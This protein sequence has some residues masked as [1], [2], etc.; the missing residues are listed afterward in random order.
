[1]SGVPGIG[2]VKAAVKAVLLSSAFLVEL[3]AIAEACADD[4]PLGLPAADAV[5]T[6]ERAH[7]AS[8]PACEI[9]GDSSEP[10]D[11]NQEAEEYAHRL[12]LVWTA[13]DDDEERVTAQIERFVLASRRVFKNAV[14]AEVPGIAPVQVGREDFSPLGRREAAGPFLKS[15]V[16]ELTV[17]TIE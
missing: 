9:V 1:M 17:P 16:L 13:I 12:A 8:Y 3:N 10:G 7:L 15:G 6:S 14:L 2:G 4:I 5:S 11:A